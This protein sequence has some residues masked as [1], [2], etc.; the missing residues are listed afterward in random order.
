MKKKIKD[1]AERLKSGYRW[2]KNIGEELV[3]KFKY[4][5]PLY[6]ESATYNEYQSYTN[7][8]PFTEEQREITQF[9]LDEIAVKTGL[10]FKMVEGT[11][12][13][14]LTFGNY[15][16]INN[17]LAGYAFRPNNY[18]GVSPIWV[19]LAHVDSFKKIITHEIGHAIGLQHVTQV[20]YSSA[21]SIMWPRVSFTKELQPADILALQQLY[22]QDTNPDPQEREKILKRQQER[23]K[24]RELRKKEQKK[25]RAAQ[26]QAEQLLA[27][28]RKR[29][30]QEVQ[31]RES[32]LAR[33]REIA[34]RQEQE[35]I[36][37]E[38][39]RVNKRRAAREEEQRQ[40]R[41]AAEEKRQRQMEE[42]AKEEARI[43]KEH[44][45]QWHRMKEERRQMEEERKKQW[46]RIKEERAQRKREYDQEYT[47]R[48]EQRARER[49]EKK[50]PPEN[51]LAQDMSS[52]T[53]HSS[54][55]GSFQGRLINRGDEQ[56]HKG[57][58]SDGV[59]L[60]GDAVNLSLR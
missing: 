41:K 35:W 56:S 42:R 9:V 48:R 39:E 59:S 33:E 27:K 60:L 7:L 34:L 44:E 47:K 17:S 51:Y 36:R 13:S 58:F 11:E 16:A 24:K 28:E 46:E 15:K 30:Q 38:Q 19:N 4:L 26:E 6:Q 25:R 37:L 23:E 5:T 12:F 53:F 22:G 52:F 50:L 32:K 10:E 8:T 14:N 3:L 45:E 57:F 18:S 2:N 31:E 29:R 20:G 49:N 43:V 21:D 40:A 54:L 55:Q 1:L